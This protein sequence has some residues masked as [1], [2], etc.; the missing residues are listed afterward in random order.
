MQKQSIVRHKKTQKYIMKH[1]D[2]TYVYT[3]DSDTGTV[4]LWFL[5]GD[6]NDV[7]QQ[8]LMSPFGDRLR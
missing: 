7:I 2:S 3:I 6:D 5:H 4:N 1:R 8:Q